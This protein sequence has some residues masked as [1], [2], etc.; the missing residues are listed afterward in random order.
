MSESAFGN[1]VF[2][3]PF[4][5]TTL[6]LSDLRQ[7]DLNLIYAIKEK[8]LPLNGYVSRNTETI[9]PLTQ[10]VD[11]VTQLTVTPYQS[12][13][14]DWCYYNPDPTNPALTGLLI[15]PLLSQSGNLAYIDR[16]NGVVYYSGVQTTPITITY[17]YYS[18][19]VQDGFPD[20]GEDIKSVDDIRLPIVTVDFSSRQPKPFAIGGTY[21]ESY[22]FIIDILA[23]S[24]PQRD[25]L[26]DLIETSLR[27]DYALTIDYKQGFPISFNGDINP[28]FDRGPAA[29]WTPIRFK[30]TSSQVIR[31]AQAIDKF[32]HRSLIKLLITVVP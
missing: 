17:D 3:R 2:G 1:V 30:S 21:Q 5:I 27:Y 25:D 16:P 31:S 32:R 26:A 15:Q 8:I 6:G 13:Y 19:M 22:N 18:V 9:T 14:F 12:T 11:P 20:W 28:T 23:N 4:D 7:I 29:R 10:S 24:D